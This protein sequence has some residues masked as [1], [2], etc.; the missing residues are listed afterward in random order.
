MRVVHRPIGAASNVAQA[1]EISVSG[2]R[3][4]VTANSEQVPAPTG[5]EPTG[6]IEVWRAAASAAVGALAPF[7][8]E[9]TYAAA[10]WVAKRW[11][12]YVERT[13][14]PA[15]REALVE[16]EAGETDR[17]NSHRLGPAQ[18]GV[19]AGAAGAALGA[20]AVAFRRR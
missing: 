14:L 11:P 2:K 19:L 4:R 12:T 1:T 16:D 17:S 8:A 20:A 13:L 9:A 5:D 6:S 7:A 3:S 18:T 15:F 10:E